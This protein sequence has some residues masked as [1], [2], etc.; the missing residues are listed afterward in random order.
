LPPLRSKFCAPRVRRGSAARSHSDLLVAVREHARCRSDA[1][2]IDQLGNSTDEPD[3]GWIIGVT[4][5]FRQVVGVDGVE[6]WQQGAGG[7]E[8]WHISANL[9]RIFSFRVHPPR[10]D[11]LG[12][13]A[14]DDSFRFF[15]FG[16]N[17]RAKTLARRDLAI[18]PRLD[19]KVL[20]TRCDRR[21]EGP[22]LLAIR[23]KNVRHGSALPAGVC[24]WRDR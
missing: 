8:D 22:F 14:D 16:A 12:A 6:R 17:D 1:L 23:N 21:D 18:E 4:R 20:K 11:C 24:A 19:P 13:P 7:D 5:P 3:P 2:T 15:E 10:L 9:A